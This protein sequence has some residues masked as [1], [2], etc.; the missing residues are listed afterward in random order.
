MVCVEFFSNWIHHFFFE[1]MVGHT[2]TFVPFEEND[3]GQV[4]LRSSNIYQIQL[5]LK[6]EDW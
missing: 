4:S 5:Q 6:T 3:V 1:D 2:V